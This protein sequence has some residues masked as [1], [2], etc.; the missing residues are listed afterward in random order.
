MLELFSLIVNLFD[1]ELLNILP[2]FFVT[3]EPDY[4]N[5]EE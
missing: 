1:I 3:D 5:Q 4:V 2:P